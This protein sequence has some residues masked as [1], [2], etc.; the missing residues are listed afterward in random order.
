MRAYLASWLGTVVYAI[1]IGEASGDVAT[2]HGA[3]WLI[4]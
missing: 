4:A 3:L 1:A 2:E